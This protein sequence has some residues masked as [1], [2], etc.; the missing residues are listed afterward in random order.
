MRSDTV[1]E[2]PVPGSGRLCQFD[3]PTAG[4]L[5]APAPIYGQHGFVPTGPADRYAAFAAAGPNIRKGN[6]PRV[7]AFDL[8]PTVSYLLD[9][10]APDDADGSV[11]RILK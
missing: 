11:L 9:I 2:V 6:V 4:Q 8:A 7:T 10:P 3:A 1:A 5:L